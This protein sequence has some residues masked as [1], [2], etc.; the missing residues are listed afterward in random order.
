M[1]EFALR[2][3]DGVKIKLGTGADMYYIRYEDRM[4]VERDE[5]SLDAAKELDLRWRLPFPDEDDT[6]IGEYDNYTRGQ[7]L[8][9]EGDTYALNIHIPEN[10]PGTI[11]LSHPSGLLINLPCYHGRKLPEIDGADVFWSGKSWSLE[12][13]QV[14]NTPA[15]IKP[16]VN[17]RHCRTFWSFEWDDVMPYINGELK[18]SI[19]HY[20]APE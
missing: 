5:N 11:Q 1:G 14:I 12:L 7:R 13:Y 10:D 19:R 4:K 2:R 6:A 18:A 3:S 15:G 17:C 20:Q 8:Y 9:T 16:I